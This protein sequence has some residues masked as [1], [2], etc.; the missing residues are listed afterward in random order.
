MNPKSFSI[1][2][3]TLVVSIFVAFPY[4]KK[5][6]YFK[7][8]VSSVN[9]LKEHNEELVEE[10]NDNFDIKTIKAKIDKSVIENA[11]WPNEVVLDEKKYF[12]K[13]GFNDDLTGHIKKLLQKFQSDYAS[14]VVM[15]NKSGSILTA[16]DF[17]G[18]DNKFGKALTFSSTHPSASLF[19]IITSAELLKQNVVTKDSLFTFSGRSHTLFKRQLKEGFSH[20]SKIQDLSEAFAVSNNIIFAKAAIKYLSSVNISSAAKD[21]GFNDSMFKEVTL[22]PSQF[23]QPED[24]Y[25]MAEVATGYNVQTTMSPVHAVLLPSI[26]VNG[27]MIK[28][29][30]IIREIRDEDDKVVWTNKTFEKKILGEV[31]SNELKDMMNKTIVEGTARHSFRK[32]KRDLKEELEIG[33]KTGSIT[34]GLPYGKRD[35]FVAFAKPKNVLEDKGISVSV[36][37]INQ[38][39]WKVK[40]TYLAKEI[41]EYFF[42]N[43]NMQNF[44]NSK[45]LA[46][47][48]NG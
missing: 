44:A 15:D 4:L 13:Y 8:S 37:I 48:K 42:K 31:A 14:V 34:G 16:L 47:V 17:S 24:P 12:I 18:I 11:E 21:F 1:A 3:V 19:K 22:Q 29:P 40:S 46:S 20:F 38:K 28:Y 32:I 7:Q 33:G 9:V 10:Q 25:Q 41:I 39:K 6:N 35:W 27:G 26:V 36:M 23:F 43:I 5:K 45:K 2:V 30:K